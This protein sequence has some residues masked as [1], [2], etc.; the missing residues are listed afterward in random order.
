[1]W[2]LIILVILIF[3]ALSSMFSSS[4]TSGGSAIYNMVK[5]GKKLK[6]LKR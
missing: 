4:V 2:Q 3:T 6:N 1:M 5:G